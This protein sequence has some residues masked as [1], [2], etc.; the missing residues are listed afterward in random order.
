MVQDLNKE[1]CTSLEV[2][3]QQV[4]A[5]SFNSQVVAGINYKVIV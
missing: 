4:T 3:E 5:L 2:G 1:I